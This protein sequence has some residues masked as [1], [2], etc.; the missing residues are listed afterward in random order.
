ML[1]FFTTFVIET[2]I[3]GSPLVPDHR[4]TSHKVHII[5]VYTCHLSFLLMIMITDNY[6]IVLCDMNNTIK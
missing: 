4:V 6:I 5:F 3:Y 1:F 2:V